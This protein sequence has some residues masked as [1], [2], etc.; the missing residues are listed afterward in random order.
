MEKD[1]QAA[2]G[3]Y[4]IEL[5][6]LERF[7]DFNFPEHNGLDER[8]RRFVKEDVKLFK[9]K[10]NALEQLRSRIAETQEVTDGVFATFD[11]LKP[12]RDLT[13]RVEVWQGPIAVTLPE[14][15][16][17]LKWGFF[18]AFAALAIGIRLIVAFDRRNRRVI[19]A[20]IGGD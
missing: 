8:L 18:V 11:R 13:C 7:I 15:S 3:E 16:R 20:P 19:Y 5:A 4:K 14:G 2:I 17:P 1:L 9:G 10:Q 12:Y 6:E